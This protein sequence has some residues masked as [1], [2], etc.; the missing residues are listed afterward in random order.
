[1]TCQKDGYFVLGISLFLFLLLSFFFTSLFLF[2][3]YGI[4]GE[5]LSSDC[6]P[7]RT[8]PDTRGLT[9]RLN[10]RLGGKHVFGFRDWIYIFSPLKCDIFGLDKGMTDMVQKFGYK[11]LFFLFFFFLFFTSAVVC[12]RTPWW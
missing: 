9:E 5:R 7:R 3:C 4:C 8:F 10:C 2:F 11:S 12:V 6:I 1:L